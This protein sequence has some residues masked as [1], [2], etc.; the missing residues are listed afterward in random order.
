M[1]AGNGG[2]G[3]E[4]VAFLCCSVARRATSDSCYAIIVNVVV[5]T[6]AVAIK[7]ATF[8][9][10]AGAIEYVHGSSTTTCAVVDE[11]TNDYFECRGFNV[12]APPACE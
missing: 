6:S 2:V 7:V 11:A 12:N 4:D 1:S 10:C 8:E 3:F 5:A 9:R